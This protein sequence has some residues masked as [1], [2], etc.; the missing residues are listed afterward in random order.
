MSTESTDQ[1]GGAGPSRAAR[2]ARGT[3][4]FPVLALRAVV[5]GRTGGPVLWARESPL[6]VAE[7]EAVAAG[8]LLGRVGDPDVEGNAQ[9]MRRLQGGWRVFFVS[10]W[11]AY[12]IPTLQHAWNSPGLLWRVVGVLSIIVFAVVYVM[13]FV[14]IRQIRVRFLSEPGRPWSWWLLSIEVALIFLTLPSAGETVL[15]MCV[16]LAVMIMFVLPP[17]Q[18]W[19]LIILDAGTVVLSSNLV[20]GWYQQ[21]VLSMQI[22]VTALA[23]WGIIQLLQR[24]NQLAQAREEITGL[25]V[26]QER[27]RFS[28]D[29]HDILGHTLTVITLKAELAGRLVQA[30]PE[31][32]AREIAEVEQLAR[33]ALADVRATVAGYRDVSLAGELVSARTALDA[34]GIEADLAGTVDDVPAERRELFGWAVREGVTNVVRHSGAQR[35]R[36]SVQRGAIEIA[37]DGRGPGGCPEDGADGDPQAGHGLAGLRERA[38]AVGA[39]LIVGRTPEGGF[40]LRVTESRGVDPAAV[41]RR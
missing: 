10:I 32:A 24:N 35:C 26:S 38:E 5:P 27:L 9:M 37:D 8:V 39:R 23:V 15:G 1:R 7:R 41:A 21:N 12:L 14:L 25:A 17:K 22:L 3:R 2:A 19:A 16:Y 13:V 4:A 11:L 29:L 33:T 40:L 20:P 28:R 18:A 31:R 36:V 30:D 34:A 6:E